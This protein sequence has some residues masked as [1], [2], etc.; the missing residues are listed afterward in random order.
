MVQKRVVTVTNKDFQFDPDGA[1]LASECVSSTRAWARRLHGTQKDKLDKPYLTHLDAVARNVVKLAGF[2][3]ELLKIAYLHDVL[4]DTQATLSDLEAEEYSDYVID[5]VLAIS[6]GKGEQNPDY[7][8]RVLK[9][10]QAAVVKLADLMHNT[11]PDRLAKL[12]THTQERLLKKY[13]TA[14]W[15]IES[16]LE[17]RELLVGTYVPTITLA[18]ALAA[19]KV[20]IGDDPSKKTQPDWKKG[21]I[22]T[23]ISGD[24]F[25][26]K[27]AT[28]YSKEYRLSKKGSKNQKTG[29][30]ELTVGDGKIV[31][32]KHSTEVLYL[33]KPFSP[34]SEA[35]RYMGFKTWAD[36]AQAHPEV[37]GDTMTA[38]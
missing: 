6:K 4:E 20:K 16:D 25:K 34:T 3:P 35:A 36:L 13:H 23:L 10:P 38:S 1:F 19:H 2:N 37:W 7:I 12:P 33:P 15:R 29:L 21:T 28:G 24:L 30:I 14:I 17:V 32:A 8:S 31:F 18:M 11:Q 26:I 27:G 22:S 5:G 9:T